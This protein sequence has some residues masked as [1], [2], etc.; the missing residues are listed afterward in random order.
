[1]STTTVRLSLMPWLFFAAVLAFGEVKVYEQ[2]LAMPTYEIGPPQVHSVFWDVREQIYPYTLNE[3]LTD[4]KVNKVYKA[5]YLEN[6]YV[7]VLILPEIGGRLHG[8]LDKTNGFEFFYWHKTIKPALVGMTGAWISGGIE[9]NFPH[10]HRPSGFML[11]D[12]RIVRN[13]DGSA[14]VWVGETEPIF[15]MRWLAGMTVFPGRSYI[16]VDYILINPTNYQYSFECWA[17]SATYAGDSVQAQYPG[18]MV[19]GHGKHQFWHWPIDHGVD[20]TWW[21]NSPNAS[22]YFAFNNPSDWFGTYDHKLQGGMVHV[23]NH[24]TMPGKKLWTW[25]SGPSGRIWEKILADGGPPYFEPQAGAWSDNQP[26]FHWMMPNE[27]KTVHDYWYA[28]RDI[29]GYHNANAD[30]ALNTDLR[31][32]MAFGGVNATG[33]MKNYRVVLKNAKTGTVLRDVVTDIAPDKPFTTEVKVGPEVTVYDLHLAVYDSSGKLCLEVQQQPPKDVP[34]PAG[35]SEPGDPKKMNLDQL[36]RAGEWLDKFRRTTEALVYYQEALRRDP[37]DLR[38]NTEM[39]FLA[40][41]Q[42][43]WNEALKY[44]DTALERDDDCSRLYFGK[45]MALEGLQ[46]FKEAYDQFYRA[47]YTADYY[48]PAYF[49]LA[50]IEMRWGDYQKALD[51]LEKAESQNRKFADIQ[52]LK[53]VVW[54]RLGK[55]LMA[56][57]A[58]EKALELDPMHFMGGR[59]KVLALQQAGKSADEAQRVWTGYMRDAVQNYLELATAYADAGLFADADAVLGDFSKGKDDARL[60][61]MVN[62]LRG[63]LKELSGDSAAAMQFYARAKK[64]PRVYTNPH[65][66]EEAAALEAAIRHDP[67]NSDAHLFLG[68]LLYS[69]GQREKALEQWEKAVESDPNNSLAWRNVGY[70]QQHLMK[71]LRASYKAY[72]KAFQIDPNDGRVLL[73]LDQVAEAL[74]IPRAERLALLNSH[75]ETVLSRDDLIAREIDL[76][77]EQGGLQN[78]QRAYDLLKNHHFHSW[79]GKYG[80]HYAWME[81]TKRLGDVAFGKKDYPMALKYYK[82]ADLYPE[83]L[84]V[85]ARTPD[86]R[87]HVYWDLARVYLAMGQKQTGEDYL[88]KILAEKYERTHL[89]TYYKALAEKALGHTAEYQ[90]LLQQVD[91]EARRRIALPDTGFRRRGGGDPRAVGHYLLSLVLAERGQTAEAEAE[92]RKAREMDIEVARNAVRE[93]QMDVSRAIQ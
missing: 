45:G 24:Q 88:R 25:G 51:S 46:K 22:S 21:K 20:L 72:Q 16:R 93:A 28:V 12:H 62:Y 23:A 31:N 92:A 44:L 43:R 71:N 10:G 66:L 33:V 35:Q 65:R 73:E 90:K 74:K 13:K 87:A 86:F 76:R 11:V 2:D 77:L 30:F 53:A 60:N 47:T 52:S 61:P 17:T 9:W 42:G 15:R 32:G 50:K 64:G 84:E 56:L 57:A 49:N 4:K 36:Y 82:E 1:M 81:A 14:T 55:P 59:E 48:A 70:A 54:R 5:V 58:A 41:K 27:V 69:K 67:Q 79:E 26:D 6:E 7:K 91:E 75:S 8:A 68:N 19:T 89:G 83:N 3:T 38:V 78:L 80:I 40:L 63:Y 37:K 34:L 18:D 39:G 29:R 85:A